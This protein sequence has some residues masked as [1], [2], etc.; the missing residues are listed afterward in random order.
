MRAFVLAGIAWAVSRR[1][2][3]CEYR[4]GGCWQK[5]MVRELVLAIGI[6]VALLLLRR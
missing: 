5:A 2:R 1:S 4:A 3:P 6:P